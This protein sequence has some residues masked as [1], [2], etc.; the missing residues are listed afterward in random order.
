MPWWVQSDVLFTTKREFVGVVLY[1]GE[2]DADMARRFASACDPRIAR[3]LSQPEAVKLPRYRSV[4]GNNSVL[5]LR[6]SPTE[7]DHEEVT[8]LNDH[9]YYKKARPSADEFPCAWGYSGIERILASKRLTL[10]DVHY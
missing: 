1:A 9:W 6:W 2:A 3:Y 8:Q 10:P 5:E 7:P 4:L